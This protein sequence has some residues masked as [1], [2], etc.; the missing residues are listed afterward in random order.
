MAWK[1]EQT[2]KSAFADICAGETPWVALGNFSND[3][4]G[5]AARRSA[6]IQE[7]IELPDGAVE[8][9]YRWAVFCAASVSYLCHKYDLACPSWVDRYPPLEQAWFH[10]HAEANPVRRERYLRTTPEEFVSRNIYCGD[11]VWL[12]K[13]AEAEKLRRRLLSA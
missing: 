2:M 6:L 3:F 8:E 11:R 4:F 12:D 10:S 13:H 5:D 9:I 7:P 1:Q